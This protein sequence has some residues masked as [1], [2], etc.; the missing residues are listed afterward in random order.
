M[1]YTSVPTGGRAWAGP[2]CS[3]CCTVAGHNVSLLAAQINASKGAKGHHFQD[4]DF[5]CFLGLVGGQGSV[6]G[7]F[8]LEDIKSLP[9]QEHVAVAHAVDK[10]HLVGVNLADNLA[11]DDARLAAVLLAQAQGVEN[12][13]P[14][15]GGRLGY[16]QSMLPAAQ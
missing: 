12:G 13:C 10:L 11:G 8:N 7:W 14:G 5:G 15:G 4:V 16:F 2:N 6:A 3:Q 1:P 9:G